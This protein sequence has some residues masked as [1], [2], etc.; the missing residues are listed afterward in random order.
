MLV[1]AHFPSRA[2]D[3]IAVPAESFELF[4]DYGDASV[5]GHGSR[6][7]NRHRSPICQ[8]E[9]AFGSHAS[10]CGAVSDSEI[11]SREISAPSGA[12]ENARVAVSG[13]QHMIVPHLF[14]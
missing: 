12:S 9:F 8:T 6:L 2:S 10:V 5:L 4:F 11:V 7:R 3:P 13:P 14:S 1:L